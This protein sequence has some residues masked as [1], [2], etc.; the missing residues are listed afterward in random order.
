[1]ISL[2]CTLQQKKG[3]GVGVVFFLFF[4][5]KRLNRYFWWPIASKF[6]SGNVKIH[7]QNSGVTLYMRLAYIVK[8]FNGENEY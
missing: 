4:F 5:L 1:M 6:F 8:G 2:F 3:G 7:A